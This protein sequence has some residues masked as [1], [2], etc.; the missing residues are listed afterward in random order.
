M[1]RIPFAYYPLIH[2]LWYKNQLDEILVEDSSHIH[3]RYVR[4]PM[5][6]DMSI[7]SRQVVLSCR[8]NI[9]TK[10]TMNNREKKTLIGFILESKE[11]NN[12][13]V[14]Y[15][16][17]DQNIVHM[18]PVEYRRDEYEINVQEDRIHLLLK[19]NKYLNR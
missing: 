2:M 5:E 1:L 12:P 4:F 10:K 7:H 8:N 6:M 13:N 3:R 16:F 11:E 17:H 15:S 18:C 14:F 19:L 9:A